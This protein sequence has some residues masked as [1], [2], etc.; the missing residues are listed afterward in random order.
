MSA[1]ALTEVF[2]TVYD[3]RRVYGVIYS[4]QLCDA[5]R[6]FKQHGLVVIRNGPWQNM[7]ENFIE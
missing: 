4:E 3:F 5:F 1:P 7:V 2:G 6:H